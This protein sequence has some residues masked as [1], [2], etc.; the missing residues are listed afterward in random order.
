MQK[1]EDWATENFERIQPYLN[2]AHTE[3]DTPFDTPE[4]LH[5]V[6]HEMKRLVPMPTLRMD[7]VVMPR[8]AGEFLDPKKI[9]HAV[10]LRYRTTLDT[11]HHSDHVPGNLEMPFLCINI[12]SA[13]SDAVRKS[14]WY[15]DILSSTGQNRSKLSSFFHDWMSGMVDG[16][17]TVA[18]TMHW[19]IGEDQDRYPAITRHNFLQHRCVFNSFMVRAVWLEAMREA[20]EF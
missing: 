5:E 18:T 10:E 11:Y 12:D 3:Y 6:F 15:C 13:L 7:S 19:A 14:P 20:G 9:M 4:Q 8:F 16:C 17:V 2:A 1:L